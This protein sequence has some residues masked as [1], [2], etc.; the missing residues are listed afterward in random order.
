MSAPDA[1]AILRQHRPILLACEAIGWFHMAGK[2][3]MEFLRKHGGQRTL[4]YDYERWHASETPP[5]DWDAILGWVRSFGGSRIPRDAWPRSVGQFIENHRRNDQGMLGLLQAG[6]GVA[7]GIEKNLPT[8]TSQYLSQSLPHMWL[9]SP[10]GHPRRNLFADPPE[11]LQRDGWRRLVEEIRRVLEELRQLASRNPPEANPPEAE[12][13][14]EWRDRAIGAHSWIRQAFLSTL[15]ET[16]VPNND[17][18]LWD[19]SYVAAALF[20]SA[21]A[22]ALLDSAFPLRDNQLKQRIRWRLLTVAIGADHYEARAVKIGDWTGMQGALEEFFGRVSRLVEV[23]LAAGSLLYQDS[24]TAVFS[25]P[26]ERFDEGVPAGWVDRLTRWIEGEIDSIAQDLDFEIPPQVR[27]S[28][29]TRSLVPL[30]QERRKAQETIAVPIHKWWQIKP[31]S[32]NGHVCPVCQVR[33]NGD[34]TNKGKPCQVCRDRRHHRREDWLSGRLGDDTIWFEEV[35]DRNGRAALITLSM[36]LEPW[37]N[38]ERVDS[39]RTQAIPEWRRFNPVLSSTPN[40]V[41]PDRPFESLWSYIQGRLS[42]FDRNDPVLRSLQEGYRH[43]PDWPTFFRRIVEDRAEAPSWHGLND[44]QRAA[45][46]VHQLFCKLPS[47]GRVYRFWREAQAFFEDLL[48]GFRQI[49]A[50]SENPWRV[51]RLLVRPQR[52][53]PGGNWR[54][55]V[56]YDGRWRGAQFSLVYIEGLGGFLT[57]SNLARLIRAEERADALRGQQITLEEEDTSGR[58]Q[59]LLVEQAQEVPRPYSHLGVYHPLILLELSPLRFRVVVPLE[60]AS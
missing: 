10:F 60:A 1:V 42:Q 52:P 25:F 11:V 12:P 40:P 43:E 32:T 4:D 31:R 36:D 38:S 14:A 44:D 49:A 23:D 50:R 55:G 46:L 30:V 2:A 35:A 58:P 54:D 48:K 53:Q 17:V 5:F 57:A 22:G 13:W 19:Q 8:L 24:S 27:L 47:P 28:N 56:L 18:T 33:L 45:W 15:A 9:S 6:H 39:L 34:P 7:S 29:P 59:P 3:R 37:L 41:D 51:R 16:R 20:K 26:G 21:V